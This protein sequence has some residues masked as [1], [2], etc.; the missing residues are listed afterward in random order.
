M[1]RVLAAMLLEQR[2]AL[3]ARPP[4]ALP[5][6]RLTACAGLER[7]WWRAATLCARGVAAN[8]PQPPFALKRV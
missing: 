3:E 8:K 1:P 2:S 4:P 6:W 7:S 5:A